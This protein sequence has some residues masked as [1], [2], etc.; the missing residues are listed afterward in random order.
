MTNP[1]AL[2]T[3]VPT[4]APTPSSTPV[5][6][7]TAATASPAATPFGNGEDP[8]SGP[9]P[10]MVRGPR[11]REMYGRLL[12]LLPYKVETVPN[13]LDPAKGTQERMT[14]DVVVLDG[15]PVQFG[16]RPEAVPPVPHDKTAQT[17]YRAERMFISAVGLVSQCREA[18]AR[19][20]QGQPGMVLGRL[21]VGEAKG[22]QK[23]PFL[24]T[25]PTDAD[26]QAARQYLAT[27]DPFA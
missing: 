4:A 9:A 11:L 26:K 27:V 23:P 6:T 17:P 25:P 10:Q 1:F 15:G 16:G 22:D 19:R 8:F 21:G 20:A 3:P 18:L 13:R 24:L 7:G 12:L 14:A 2:D 5:P